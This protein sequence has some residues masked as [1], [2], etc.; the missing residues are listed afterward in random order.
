VRALA[1]L[2]LA[3]G[4]AYAQAPGE[5]PSQPVPQSAPTVMNDRWAISLGLMSEGLTP[6]SSGSNVQFGGIDVAGHY[7]FTP[8][9]ELGLSFLAAGSAG[10]LAAA[11]LAI[12]MHYRFFPENPWNFYALGA[13]GVTS[14]GDQHA[15]N[16]EKKGR[17]T[18]HLGLGG[19]RRFGHIGVGAQLFLIHVGDNTVPALPRSTSSATAQKLE[20]DALNGG[21]LVVGGTIYF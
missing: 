17:G 18:L 16:D 20:R 2:V 6:K 7:R 15:N 14:A 9:L 10:N 4:T 19:E 5:M 11:G 8:A 13:L 3:T 21:A 12:D 1:V